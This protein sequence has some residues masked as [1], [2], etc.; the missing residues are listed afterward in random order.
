[1]KIT[2]TSMLSGVTRTL[3]IPVTK[4][5]LE[6]WESGTLIQRAMPR[7]SADER[8]FVKTGVVQA[9]WD[10]EFGDEE[11]DKVQPIEVAVQVAGKN[12]AT[13]VVEPYTTQ[14]DV[15]ATARSAVAPWICGRSIDKTIVVKGCLVNF[16]TTR[17]HS[18]RE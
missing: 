9:E 6:A 18:S 10:N 12:R 13:I 2:R 3:D 14:N 17:H 8:E 4:A 1:M 11:D 15:I 5:Q 16:I 7:L